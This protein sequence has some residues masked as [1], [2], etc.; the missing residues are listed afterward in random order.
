[1]NKI[2]AMIGRIIHDSMIKSL[3][4]SNK[5]ALLFGARQVGKTTLVKRILDSIDIDSVSINGDDKRYAEV[6]SS[7]DLS[8]M[9][10]VVG[11][12]MLLFID[13][14]QNI[15]HIGEGLKLLNDNIPGLK[16]IATGSSSFELANKTSESLTGR[17]RTYM[18][19]PISVEEI[20][21]TMTPFEVKQRLDEFLTFGM[22]PDIIT[23]VE[24]QEKI[25][26][27][28]ELSNAYLYK[29][30][31]QLSGIR[32]ADKIHKLLRLIALQIGNLVSVHEIAKQIN[33]SHET[34]VNY[35]DVLEKAFIVFRLSGLSRNPRKEVSKMDKIYFYDLGIRNMLIENFNPIELRQD[36]G[37]LFENF[38][39]VE[40]MKKQMY[41]N[42]FHK[43]FFWRTYT[44]VEIDYVEE[45]NQ[46]L[47]GVEIKWKPRKPK[48]P[49]SWQDN[50]PDSSYVQ[51]DSEN[52]I[53]FIT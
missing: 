37:A 21:A 32:H 22:Y 49:K 12:K 5:V 25:T 3:M 34:V 2:Y 24:N 6:F 1:M 18:L 46:K 51:I 36:K 40:R 8:K 20:S 38:I 42:V 23:S 29:D 43:A 17:S 26:N 52:F 35:I 4:T 10:E 27:L 45:A 41:R 7:Q 33:L 44:G 19:F 47:Q 9:K 50:Y 28:R 48:E 13:E 16:I 39:I 14:A 15:S 53:D 31:L 30:I 11:N